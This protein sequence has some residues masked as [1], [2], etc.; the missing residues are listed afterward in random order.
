MK[1]N[2]VNV[3]DGIICVSFAYGYTVSLLTLNIPLFM[4]QERDDPATRKAFM[5]CAR[6]SGGAYSQFDRASVSHLRDLLKAVAVYAAGGYKA[7]KNFTKNS[8]K[9]VKLLE[10]QLKS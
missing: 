2:E 5:E 10:R 4:F 6:L 1:N 3:L 7:L 9:E 8:A